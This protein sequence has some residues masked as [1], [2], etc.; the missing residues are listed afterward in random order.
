MKIMVDPMAALR[1]AAEDKV[2]NF[3]NVE[4]TLNVHR[5]QEYAAKREA[6][7][8]VLAGGVSEHLQAEAD[9]RGTSAETLAKVIVSKPNNVLER[10]LRRRKALMAVQNAKTPAEVDA[11]LKALGARP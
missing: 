2:E 4:A 7:K 5:D 9:L 1:R 3:F 10:G 8:A 6:A 11:V